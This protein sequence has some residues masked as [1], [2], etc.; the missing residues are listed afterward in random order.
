MASLLEERHPLC[1]LIC[2]RFLAS[3]LFDY[4]VAEKLKIRAIGMLREGFGSYSNDIKSQMENNFE[5]VA[6][7]NYLA[8]YTSL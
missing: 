2:S 3:R 7:K 4:K 6:F 5:L 8:L 1:L